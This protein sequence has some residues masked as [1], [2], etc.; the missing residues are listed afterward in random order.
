MAK[1]IEYYR[2]RISQHPILIKTILIIAINVL[3]FQII[4]ADRIIWALE[5]FINVFVIIIIPFMIILYVMSLLEKNR[6]FKSYFN[7][8]PVKHSNTLYNILLVVTILAIIIINF[9]R[10]LNQVLLSGNVFYWLKFVINNRVYFMVSMILVYWII[11]MYFSNQKIF[12]FIPH[13][14]L[15]ITSL[16]II[17]NNT[18]FVLYLLIIPM[19]IETKKILNEEG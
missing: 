6:L 4:T 18:S 10:L 11:T 14:I 9:L 7:Y 5:T 19:I 8:N 13:I 16:F 12:K 17:P 15:V 3:L 2:L 1:L